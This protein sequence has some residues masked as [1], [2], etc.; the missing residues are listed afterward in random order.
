M[1][2]V[3]RLCVPEQDGGDG[4]GLWNVMSYCMERCV[5]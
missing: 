3:S 5:L 2:D 4:L 1:E